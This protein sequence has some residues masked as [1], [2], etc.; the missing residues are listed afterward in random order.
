MLQ[1]SVQIRQA[2]ANTFI[3]ISAALAVAFFWAYLR[4]PQGN[5]LIVV[6]SF[7]SAVKISEY[8]LRKKQLR[9]LAAITAGAVIMQFMVSAANNCQL[10]ALFLPPPA[11]NCKSGATVI[12]RAIPNFCPR[13]IYFIP[14]LSATTTSATMTTVTPPRVIT[15][16]TT[17]TARYSTGIF[18][19]ALPTTIYCANSNR[20]KQLPV[21]ICK[22]AFCK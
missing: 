9:V 6:F 13:S 19:T 22:T 11:S 21:M 8:P 12:C 4:I 7:L 17:P 1:L 14:A 16:L 5:L 10:L 18:L 20:W 2:L 3:L 15:T